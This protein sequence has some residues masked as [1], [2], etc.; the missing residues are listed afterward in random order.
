MVKAMSNAES[1]RYDLFL[2]EFK[3]NPGAFRER[4]KGDGTFQF[5][6]QV[7]ELETLSNKINLAMTVYLFGDILGRHM[8]EKFVGQ[9]GRNLLFFLSQLTSEYRMFILHELK[10]NPKLFLQG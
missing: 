4:L 8:A 9:C 2:A 7:K 6:E 1:S 10:N 5:C 3:A